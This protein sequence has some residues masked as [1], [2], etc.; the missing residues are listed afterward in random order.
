MKMLSKHPGVP[1]FFGY[2]KSRIKNADEDL[3]VLVN[4]LCEHGDLT[5][6]VET[7]EFEAM[8]MQDR[9]L[10]CVDILR[11]LCVMHDEDIYHRRHCLLLC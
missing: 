1:T 8:S 9:L 10:L 4:E 6:F 5:E 2:C 11:V 7:D 3:I